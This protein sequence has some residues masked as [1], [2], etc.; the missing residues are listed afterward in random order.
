MGVEIDAPIINEQSLAANMTNEGGVAGRFCFL[1]NIMGMWLLQECRRSWEQEGAE[2]D[3]ATLATLGEQAQPLVTLIN[4]DDPEFFRPLGM[5]DRIR[6]YAIRTNQPAPQDRGAMVR[7]IL[8]SLALRYKQ[9]LLQLEVLTG[10][11]IDTIH[12][13][14]GGCQNE[15]LNQLTA[16]ATGCTVIAGPVEATAAGN[17]LVQAISAG[18]LSGIDE[19]RAVIRRSF[20]PKV[21][22][23]NSGAGWSEAYERFSKLCRS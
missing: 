3:Y 22:T 21:Y 1:K 15:L 12:I 19:G 11:H 14:G 2:L 16:N 9:V 6:E 17:I 20:A 23:P 13:V 8:E 4:P 5:P 7:C 18:T 10:R